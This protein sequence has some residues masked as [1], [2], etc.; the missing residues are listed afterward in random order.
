[1]TTITI[2]DSLWRHNDM[3]CYANMRSQGKTFCLLMLAFRCHLRYCSSQ[4]VDVS[5]S[6]SAVLHYISEFLLL[7]WVNTFGFQHKTMIATARHSVP[8][9]QWFY[10]LFPMPPL[11]HRTAHTDLVAQQGNFW[12]L[13]NNNKHRPGAVFTVFLRCLRVLH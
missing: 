6:H 11:A 8:R 1:M 3:Y 10:R 5:L 12:Q 13:L 2:V 9:N 4:E 7:G